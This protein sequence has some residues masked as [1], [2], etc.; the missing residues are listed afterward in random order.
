MKTINSLTSPPSNYS[1]NPK[2]FRQRVYHS[3]KS[4]FIIQIKA[5]IL[6]NKVDVWMKGMNVGELRATENRIFLLQTLTQVPHSSAWMRNSN[7]WIPWT[8]WSFGEQLGH[9]KKHPALKRSLRL[10]N[11]QRWRRHK[12]NLT[13]KAR[14]SSQDRVLFWLSFFGN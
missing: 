5:L 11:T 4:W 7:S 13:K 1:A 14:Q 6:G 8:P 9:K 10:K 2:N 12:N 3:I